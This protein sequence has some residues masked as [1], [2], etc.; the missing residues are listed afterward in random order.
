MWTKQNYYSYTEQLLFGTWHSTKVLYTFFQNYYY[1]IIKLLFRK[2]KR[3]IGSYTNKKVLLSRDSP[4]FF[5]AFL[6][7]DQ[8]FFLK[9]TRTAWHRFPFRNYS[10]VVFAFW[11]GYVKS[12][13]WLCIQF[14]KC[15]TGVILSQSTSICQPLCERCVLLVGWSCW[16]HSTRWMYHHTVP[17]VDTS[18]QSAGVCLWGSWFFWTRLWWHPSHLL[19]FQLWG[20]LSVSH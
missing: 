5:P 16:P 19:G 12:V 15:N 18:L 6:F 17:M 3:T 14:V 10:T 8:I 1:L 13:E 2:Q 7:F 11:R 9:L 4:C 20:T